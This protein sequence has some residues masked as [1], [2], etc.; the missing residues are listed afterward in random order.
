MPNKQMTIQ[1]KLRTKERLFRAVITIFAMK[2][3]KWKYPA[4]LSGTYNRR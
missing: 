3:I 1:Q 4:K 2:N